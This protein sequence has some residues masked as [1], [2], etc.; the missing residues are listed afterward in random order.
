VLFTSSRPCA[1]CD[2]LGWTAA[3]PG[4]LAKGP[5]DALMAFD[6]E[7]QLVGSIKYAATSHTYYES[8][9]DGL[10]VRQTAGE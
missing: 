8:N 3:G 2:G 5:Q 6:P 1:R 9:A 4:E 10:L 7:S